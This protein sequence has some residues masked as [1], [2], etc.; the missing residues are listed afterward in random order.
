MQRLFI[1]RVD[2]L[3]PSPQ[4]YEKTFY[5]VSLQRL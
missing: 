2:E 4:I 5:A 1:E 3:Y